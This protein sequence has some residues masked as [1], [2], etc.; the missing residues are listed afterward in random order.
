MKKVLILIL[1]GNLLGVSVFVASYMIS[2]DI[3]KKSNTH[4]FFSETEFTHCPP[5]DCPGRECLCVLG[6]N[7]TWYFNGTIGD[8]EELDGGIFTP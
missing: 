2:E 8:L 6:N 1:L 4:R 7:K 3:M 5:S